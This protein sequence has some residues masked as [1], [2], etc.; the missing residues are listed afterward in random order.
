MAVGE[1]LTESTLVVTI[2]ALVIF[3][4]RYVYIYLIEIQEIPCKLSISN[5]FLTSEKN[6]SVLLWY[7]IANRIK[8]LKIV[9][10]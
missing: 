1:T 4:Y 8:I 5:T 9:G 7:E 10:D 2:S 3:I 6:Y